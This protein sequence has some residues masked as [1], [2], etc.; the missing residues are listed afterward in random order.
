M[1]VMAANV[2]KF[3]SFNEYQV[4]THKGRISKTVA[5]QKALAE[6]AGFN[7][8]QRIE[9]DFDRVVKDVKALAEKP[10]SAKRK[11]KT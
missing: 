6:Y 3:L 9:S 1:I 8:A 7:K 4:L 5:D 2:D 11:N 10:K